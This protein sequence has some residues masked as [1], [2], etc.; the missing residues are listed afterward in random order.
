MRHRQERIQWCQDY[1][2]WTQAD[3]ASVLFTDE[4]RFCLHFHDGR[5]K[6]WRRPNERY[7]DTT[8]VEHD[9]YGGGPVTVWAAISL[10]GHTDLAPSPVWGTEMESCMHSETLCWDYWS[11]LHPDGWQCTTT[12]GQGCAAV[13]AGW[14][15]WPHGL[16]STLTRPQPNWACLGPAAGCSFSSSCT[17]SQFARARKCTDGEVGR[18]PSETAHQPHREHE[19]TMPSCDTCQRT[20][21]TVLVMGSILPGEEL[22][23]VNNH[24]APGDIRRNIQDWFTDC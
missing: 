7:C 12:W 4:S 24:T 9:R 21:H 2:V 11:G 5:Y 14:D 1:V 3:W 15:H 8:V 6:V 13:F 20:P 19:K 18:Y 17:T 22:W 16:A 23:W 10:R